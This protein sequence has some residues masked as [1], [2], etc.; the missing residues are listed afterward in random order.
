MRMLL[1]PLLGTA[2]FSHF[3]PRT[4]VNVH[5]YASALEDEHFRAL[6]ERQEVGRAHAGMAWARGGMREA[7]KRVQSATGLRVMEALGI[8]RATE[9]NV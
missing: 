2:V 4:S 3:H 5:A 6:A 1:P 9:G 8:A 7:V